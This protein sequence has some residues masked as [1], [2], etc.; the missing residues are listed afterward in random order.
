MRWEDFRRSDNV[1]DMRESGG[2]YGGGGGFPIGGGGLGIGTILV[3][4]VLGWALGIDPRLLIGGAE[5]LTGGNQRYEQPYQEPRGREPAQRGAPADE[6]GGFVAAVL[7]NTE[8]VW[9]DVFRE[10]GRRYQPPRLRLFAGAVQGGCG[11]AQ[12]AMGPFY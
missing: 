12:A 11:F 4:G 9:G 6:A 3:L 8:D 1:E 5:I 10:S 2:G 7:G